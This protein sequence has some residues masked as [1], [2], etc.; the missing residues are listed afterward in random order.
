MQRQ[1]RTILIALLLALSACADPPDLGA[2]IILEIHADPAYSTMPQ[3][4]RLSLIDATGARF[5]K[6]PDEFG[7]TFPVQVGTALATVSP[8]VGAALVSPVRVTSVGLVEGGIQAAFTTIAWGSGGRVTVKLRERP[9]ECTVNGALTCDPEGCCPERWEAPPVVPPPTKG[10]PT[11]PPDGGASDCSREDCADASAV[12]LRSS[13]VSPKPAL[14]RSRIA[15]WTGLTLG[16]STRV[17]SISS[18]LRRTHAIGRPADAAGTYGRDGTSAPDALSASEDDKTAVA[19]AKT[20][21]TRTIAFGAAGGAAVL[22]GIILSVVG[23]KPA[24]QRTATV[25]PYLSSRSLGLA[26]SF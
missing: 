12:G 4:V 26:G 6:S 21:R 23:R 14:R 15:G 2:R 17:A 8:R 7:W 16:I 10:G 20:W 18:M 11:R 9:S 24:S 22:T 3:T 5:P 19:D 1:L 13:G 25:E